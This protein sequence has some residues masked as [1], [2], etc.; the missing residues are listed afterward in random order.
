MSSRSE[1]RIGATCAVVGSVLLLVGTFL[2]PMGA[3]PNEAAAAFAEYAADRLWIASHLAQLAGVALMVAALLLLAQQLAAGDG[4]GWSRLAAGGA[5]AS[6]AVAAALQAV[7]GIA[8]K[9]MVD[10]WAVAPAAQKEIAFQAAFAV[11]QV[12]TGLASMASLSFG[13]T[14][15]VYGGTLLADQTYPKWL[16]AFAVAAGADTMVAGIVMAYTGFSWLAMAISMP[17][18]LILLVWMLALGGFMWRR[19]E[20]SPIETV[21]DYSTE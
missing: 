13:L 11:R 17:A 21:A 7:D 15:I 18:G 12:E 6:L 5:T 16:G 3:D 1:S 9:A 2:H 8:L 14:T 20:V 10:T 19:R 4:A